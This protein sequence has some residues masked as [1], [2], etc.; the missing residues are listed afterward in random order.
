MKKRRT[1]STLEPAFWFPQIWEKTILFQ[2][3]LGMKIKY[4][5]FSHEISK[6]FDLLFNDVVLF[7]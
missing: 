7:S 5:I 6:I 1:V 4:L 3:F 2:K